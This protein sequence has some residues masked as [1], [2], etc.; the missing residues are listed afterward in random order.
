MNRITIMI[1]LIWTLTSCGFFQ[2]EIIEPTVEL[3]PEQLEQIEKEKFENLLEEEDKKNLKI[4]QKQQQLEKNRVDALYDL[5]RSKMTQ[6]EINE[7]NK[8]LNLDKMKI[9][10]ITK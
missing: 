5:E 3:T 2:E 4:I 7:E 10:P 6:E 8:L 9:T 1:L